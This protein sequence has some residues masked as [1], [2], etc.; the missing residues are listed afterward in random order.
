LN[1][2]AYASLAAHSISLRRSHNRLQALSTLV[3]PDPRP[4]WFAESLAGRIE[5]LTFPKEEDG[6]SGLKGGRYDLPAGVP[7]TRSQPRPSTENRAGTDVPTPVAEGGCLG[8]WRHAGADA[9]RGTRSQTQGTRGPS[10]GGW[11]PGG[12]LADIEHSA[13]LAQQ[14]FQ[15]AQKPRP[16]L[17]PEEFL[18]VARPPLSQ[19]KVGQ[20]GIPGNQ[21]AGWGLAL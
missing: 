8:P 16:L 17:Q 14:Q 4:R 18:H 11:A 19:F 7:G 3:T 1:D 9:A 15:H 20:P 21:D 6:L 13:A 5:L 10:L 12:E 2:P